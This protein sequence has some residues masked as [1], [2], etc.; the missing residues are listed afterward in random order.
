[1]VSCFLWFHVVAEPNV[2]PVI[3]KRYAYFMFLSAI[4][5]VTMIELWRKKRWQG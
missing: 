4:S 5:Y 2:R 3:R 1:M